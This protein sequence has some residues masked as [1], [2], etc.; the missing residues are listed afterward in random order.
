[1]TVEEFPFLSLSFFSYLE[2]K[3]KY[4][5]GAKDSYLSKQ[6]VKIQNFSIAKLS[7][8]CSK[9]NFL[10]L[11]LTNFNFISFINLIG[12]WQI[13]CN[14]LIDCDSIF[15][16]EFT[17]A[18]NFRELVKLRKNIIVQLYNSNT[19]NQIFHVHERACNSFGIFWLLYKSNLFIRSNYSLRLIILFII[20]IV[21]IIHVQTRI[22]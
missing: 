6:N 2:F 7:L 12:K 4:Q 14:K 13:F 19:N 21:I 8:R 3:R 9:K 5:I 10:I 18:R 11:Y 16:V 1:V 17:Y 20:I 15:L 22:T